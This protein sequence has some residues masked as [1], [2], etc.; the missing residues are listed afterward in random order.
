MVT[1]DQM[2]AAVSSTSVTVVHVVADCRG[3]QL[4]VGS[5][6]QLCF[7]GATGPKVGT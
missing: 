5:T 1:P 7:V 6:R 4:H 2:C 3:L